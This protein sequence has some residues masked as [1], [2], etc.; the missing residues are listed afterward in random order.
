MVSYEGRG[1]SYAFFLRSC[2]NTMQETHFV[3][4]Q[5]DSTNM[6][7][8]VSKL[9][10]RL[11]DEWQMVVCNIRENHNRK[12]RV[13]GLLECLEKASKDCTRSYLW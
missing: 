4:A 3:E 1:W 11:S 9:P 6:R 12:A 5:E 10:F 8:I 13:K 2:Y 7:I